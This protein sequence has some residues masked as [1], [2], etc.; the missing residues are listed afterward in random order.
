[1]ITALGRH[2]FVAGKPLP[3]AV[4]AGCPTDQTYTSYR[5]PQTHLPA[6]RSRQIRFFGGNL[7]IFKRFDYWTNLSYPFYLKF[8]TI[9]EQNIL[10]EFQKVVIFVEK[11]R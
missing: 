11:M 6:C 9:S 3:R 1:M 8:V 10:S 4:D 5:F 2:P 7:L